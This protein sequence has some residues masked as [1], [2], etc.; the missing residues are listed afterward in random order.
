MPYDIYIESK[1]TYSTHMK[2]LPTALLLTFGF[3]GVVVATAPKDVTTTVAT[4]TTT[5][6]TSSQLAA[7]TATFQH[8]TDETAKKFTYTTQ[9]NGIENITVTYS[10]G[11]M[12]NYSI[13]GRD[14]TNTRVWITTAGD[15]TESTVSWDGQTAILKTENN[16]TKLGGFRTAFNQLLSNRQGER[17]AEEAAQ[18]AREERMA[19]FN[20]E[21]FDEMVSRLS[22]QTCIAAEG[23][24][25][26][27]QNTIINKAMNPIIRGGF[28]MGSSNQ[29]R[30][31]NMNPRLRSKNVLNAMNWDCNNV[32]M[33][34]AENQIN[35]AFSF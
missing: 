13:D 5:V 10:D 24:G 30:W 19:A 29:A 7:G 18:A 3:I 26:I 16:T 21:S 8:T 6:Q 35:S 17:R 4:T 32:M 31:N 9:V 15:T 34:A 20:N 22:K 25:Y 27:T 33:V 28:E 2:L 11:V 1:P 14:S 12:V 23:L